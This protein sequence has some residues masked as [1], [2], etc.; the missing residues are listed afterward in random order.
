MSHAWVQVKVAQKSRRKNAETEPEVS[1][2]VSNYGL[3]RARN[4]GNRARKCRT[5]PGVDSEVPMTTG[6]AH[7]TQGTASDCRIASVTA[8]ANQHVT[9]DRHGH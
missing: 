3:E 5:V 8:S 4:R 7:R 1:A 6:T 9:D 2:K